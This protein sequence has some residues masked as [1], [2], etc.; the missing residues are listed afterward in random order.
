MAAAGLTVR[1]VFTG[2]RT[3][4]ASV[5]AAADVYCHT[6]TGPEPFG[7]A[8]VEALHA[9]LPVLASRLGGPPRSGVSDDGVYRGSGGSGG[10]DDGD[11]PPVQRIPVS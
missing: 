9:G 11:E 5:L 1:V 2:H 7:L 8:I 10:D 3:D 4:V 6:N